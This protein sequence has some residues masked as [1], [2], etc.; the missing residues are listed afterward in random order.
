MISVKDIPL[1]C[2][3]LR[4]NCVP[5]GLAGSSKPNATMKLVNT[6]ADT[7]SMPAPTPLYAD[8]VSIKAH[9]LNSAHTI[10]HSSVRVRV[11]VSFP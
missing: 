10:S 8:V 7:F 3:L 2:N 4:G 1:S 5:T 9:T 11:V 6:S